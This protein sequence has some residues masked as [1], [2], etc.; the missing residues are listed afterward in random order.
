M[1]LS[2]KVDGAERVR[3]LLGGIAAAA[4][5]TQGPII[6]LSSDAPYARYVEEGVRGRPARRMFADGIAAMRSRIGPRLVPALLKGPSAVDA[7]KRKLNDEAV[8]EVRKRTPVRTGRLRAS[9][10]PSGRAG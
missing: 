6:S 4:V 10:H 7:E 1:Q 8:E 5:R 3:S 2:I 9:V